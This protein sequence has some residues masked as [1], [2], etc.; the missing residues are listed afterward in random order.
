MRKD[1]L[2]QGLLAETSS[3]GLCEVL[4]EL[5]IFRVISLLRCI[6]DGMTVMNDTNLAPVCLCT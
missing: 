6:V 5:K 3:E 4:N 1:I 2:M